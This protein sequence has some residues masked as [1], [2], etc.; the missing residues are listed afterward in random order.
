MAAHY[1]LFKSPNPRPGEEDKLHARFVNRYIIRPDRLAKEISDICSFSSADVKG[2]LDALR[3]RLAFHLEYGGIVELEDIGFFSA[4]LKC[5][6]ATTSRQIRAPQVVFNKVNFRCAKRLK[7]DLRS[8][9]VEPNPDRHKKKE[10]TEEERRQN[11]LDYLSSYPT[12]STSE[13]R[14]MNACSQYLALKDL[15]TLMKEN[16]IFRVG[17]K[18]NAQ[19]TLVENEE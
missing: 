13:C 7:E 17:S 1:D 19:Y 4:S 3:S 12:V 5:P 18:N 14:G 15:N 2:M 11:I 6:A 10:L 9:E 8:M 16:K